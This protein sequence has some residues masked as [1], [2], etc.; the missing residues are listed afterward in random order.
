MSGVTRRITLPDGRHL[1][2][3]EQG[4]PD[5]RPVV[6]CHS[7]PGSRYDWYLF[8]SQGLAEKLHIRV[9][10]PDRPG[11]GISDFQPRREIGDWPADLA[12]L[13]DALGLERFPIFGYSGGSPYVAACAYRIP[14]RLTAAGIIS[15]T[16]PDGLPGPTAGINPFI[17][18][19]LSLARVRPALA[20]QLFSLVGSLS[21]GAPPS[22]VAL[23]MGT[24]PEP[25]RGTLARPRLRQALVD[26]F[27][28]ALRPGP[29]GVSRDVALMV[30]PWGFAPQE[31]AMPV[32]LWHGG[33]DSIVVPSMARHLANAIPH[34]RARFYPLE[35]HVSLMVDHAEEILRDLIEG[36]AA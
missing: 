1:G 36:G 16:G 7:T 3:D 25:D 2:Y 8:G 32:V 20:R 19:W 9:I 35:G 14:E 34:G 23:A 27:Q 15:G 30:S 13:A 12:V 29:R 10:T 6:Y 31:I 28:E 33:K 26:A 5:G 4:P 11:I 24:L 18:A 17:F 22:L 21:R